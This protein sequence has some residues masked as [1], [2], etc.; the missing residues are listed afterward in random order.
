MFERLSRGKKAKTAIFCHCNSFNAY[1]VKKLKNGGQ[2]KK[3]GN[4]MAELKEEI[5]EHLINNDVNWLL[6]NHLAVRRNDWIPVA[7]MLPP[8]GIAC[9]VVVEIELGPQKYI[10]KRKITKDII[11]RAA[12]KEYPCIIAW[13][14][15][16]LR[17]VY[18]ESNNYEDYKDKIHREVQR[19][20]DLD[21]AASL[22][23]ELVKE[24][25]T[26]G[27]PSQDLLMEA[28]THFR[29]HHD[30]T[31]ADYYALK[32]CVRLAIEKNGANGAKEK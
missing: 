5:R 4:T 2:F 8:E 29:S 19:S 14:P 17:P 18:D 11:E 27:E 13:M 25:E 22:F 28:V 6:E 26:S 31:L 30:W 15:P 16:E 23:E 21:D 10:D 7:K 12:R 32:E 3:G 24:G 20:Y 1:K 9:W